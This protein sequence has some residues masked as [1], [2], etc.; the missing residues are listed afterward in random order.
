MHLKTRLEQAIDKLESAAA[1]HECFLI[2]CRSDDH[3]PADSAR[4]LEEGR[5]R[6]AARNEIIHIVERIS[7]AAA[8]G[9]VVGFS[10][11]EPRE[12]GP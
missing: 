10:L 6:H 8:R 7:A 11:T 3:T 5:K 4:V 12:C 9:R 2:K 1:A